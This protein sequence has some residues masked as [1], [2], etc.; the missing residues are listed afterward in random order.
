MF[1]GLIAGLLSFS[2]EEKLIELR[3]DSLRLLLSLIDSRKGKIHTLCCQ[4]KSNEI[5]D[6]VVCLYSKKL[7]FFDIFMEMWFVKR[8]LAVWFPIYQPF[9]PAHDPQ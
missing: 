4:I 6:V 9:Q 3:L 2:S 7:P 8:T 5:E 1:G